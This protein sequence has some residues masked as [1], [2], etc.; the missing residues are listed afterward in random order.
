M[1]LNSFPP[2]AQG[3]KKRYHG[4]VFGLFLS[5]SFFSY[6]ASE[7]RNEP[8][9][10]LSGSAPVHLH[11]SEKMGSSRGREGYVCA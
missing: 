4:L 11:Q 8:M 5:S 3:R 1:A 6:G 9:M 7:T 2:Q 10:L